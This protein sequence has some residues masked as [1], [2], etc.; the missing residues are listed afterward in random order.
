M[1]T[2]IKQAYQAHGDWAFAAACP[3]LRN[4]LPPHLRD[5]DLPYW[6]FLRSL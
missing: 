1:H 5:A 3:G 4:S 2:H 6:R